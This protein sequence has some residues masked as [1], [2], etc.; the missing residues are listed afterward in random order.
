MVLNCSV[1]SATVATVRQLL[2]ADAL[3]AEG[4]AVG[5]VQDLAGVAGGRGS[6]GDHLRVG[7]EQAA[8][9]LAGSIAL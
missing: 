3:L 1:R 6:G 5:R 2:H 8:G 7:I 4:A 9:Q